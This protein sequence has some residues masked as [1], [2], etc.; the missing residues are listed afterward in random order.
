MALISLQLEY[1]YLDLHMEIY[2]LHDNQTENF[3]LVGVKFSH[4]FWLG[5]YFIWIGWIKK[6]GTQVGI[7][8]FQVRVYFCFYLI[9]QSSECS[10]VKLKKK[11]FSDPVERTC[12]FSSVVQIN[13]VVLQDF[14][15][16]ILFPFDFSFSNFVV[17]TQFIKFYIRV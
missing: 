5:G 15:F 1:K 13:M 7:I 16:F 8:G 10:L 17:G 3:T 12:S 11:K 6:S 2:L 9:H 4:W 14:L